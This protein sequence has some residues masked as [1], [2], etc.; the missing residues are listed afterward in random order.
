MLLR[1]MQMEEM[2]LEARPMLAVTG[3]LST[4]KTLVWA[5]PGPSR[6]EWGVERESQAHREAREL[7]W[8]G[9]ER[10]VPART[11]G[12]SFLHSLCRVSGV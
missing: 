8:E 11:K 6:A 5:S 2:E 4:P 10:R 7:P 3:A 1:N 9:A 12:W